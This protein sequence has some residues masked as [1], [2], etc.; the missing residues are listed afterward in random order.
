MRRNYYPH[1][2][3]MENLCS[4]KFPTVSLL[5]VASKWILVFAGDLNTKRTNNRKQIKMIR[6]LSRHFLQRCNASVTIW[7]YHSVLG[8]LVLRQRDQILTGSEGCGS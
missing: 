7:S 5:F 6:I 8:R 3:E 4:E 2:K 1:Q